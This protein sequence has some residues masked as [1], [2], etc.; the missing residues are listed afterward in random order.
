MEISS[1]PKFL[2]LSMKAYFLCARLGITTFATRIHNCDITL[3]L[4]DGYDWAKTRKTIEDEV[5]EMR[6]RLARIKQLVATGQAYDPSMEDT[7]ALLFNSVYIGLEHDVDDLDSNALIAAIDEE[8][9]EE[10]ETT[11]QS[12]WQSLKPR[13]GE[14]SKARSIGIHGKRLTRSRGPSMEFRA[15]GA[16]AEVDTYQP[17]ETF[18]SRALVTIRDL[19][20]LDHIKTSTWQK[21]LTELRT[22]SR[23]NVRETDSNMVRVELLKVRPVPGHPS[24]EARLRVS[25]SFFVLRGCMSCLEPQAKIL[26]LRLFVDQDALD[27]LKKFF[28]F[29]D[30][31]AQPAPSKESSGGDIYFRKQSQVRLLAASSLSLFVSQNSQK[32]SP[33]TS[34]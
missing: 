31:H 14:K 4:Y 28:S 12:S 19:E 11:S 8:L 5:K 10:L 29:Q 23:N 25:D 15:M 13:P 27:F 22:D 26:P 2:S 17:T 18:L 30:P 21:F 33:S 3:F 7:S 1:D 6:K 34:S 9:N 20:I 32:S 24:E 16:A